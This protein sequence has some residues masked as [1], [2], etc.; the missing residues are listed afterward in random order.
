MGER[1]VD[2]VIQRWRDSARAAMESGEEEAASPLGRMLRRVGWW[3]AALAAAVLAAV[4]LAAAGLVL[5]GGLGRSDPADPAS[6]PAPVIAEPGTS[7]A[8]SPTDPPRPAQVEDWYAI[9]AAADGARQVAYQSADP[10]ALAAAFAPGGPAMAQEQARV[11]ALASSGATALG[12]QTELLAVGQL[13]AGSERAMLRVR[14]RRLAY[15][16]RDGAGTQQVA[17][18]GQATW[19]VTMQRSAGQWLIQAV[20]PEI[21]NQSGLP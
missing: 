5:L 10:A 13:E 2:R 21:T 16:V 19:V 12:W 6:Q 7:P 14:D 18:A 20:V 4:G 1:E 3:R 11:A 9:I 8:P 17:A 15:Q